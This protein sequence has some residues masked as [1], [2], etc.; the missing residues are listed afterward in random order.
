MKEEGR[1]KR[2]FTY[3]WNSVLSHQEAAREADGTFPG[4]FTYCF[5]TYK[6]NHN[7]RIFH[8]Y[9]TETVKINLVL[10]WYKYIFNCSR[11]LTSY[12]FWKATHIS[13][14]DCKSSSHLH[15]DCI[16]VCLCTCRGVFINVTRKFLII[17]CKGTVDYFLMNA[18]P[19][20][21]LTVIRD[22]SLLNMREQQRLFHS[23]LPANCTSTERPTYMWGTEAESFAFNE[24]VGFRYNRAFNVNILLL[25]GTTL[26]KQCSGKL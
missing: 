3:C 25:V 9:A 16:S 14:I 11:Y 21:D 23:A 22:Q 5:A 10:I 15:V 7:L 6:T 18:M 26:I 20:Q 4:C 12:Y 8:F 17:I 19:F 1:I 24:K 13:W 2:S